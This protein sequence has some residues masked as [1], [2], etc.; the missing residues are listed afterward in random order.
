[1]KLA[2]I[3]HT[4]HFKT[5]NG[6]IVGWSSTVNEINH[7][8]DIFDEIYHVA[9][10]HAAEAP[11]SCLAYASSKIKFVPLKPLGGHTFQ[12]KLHT[13]IQ[14][15]NVIHTVRA[16]LK[17][18]DCFQFRAPTGIGVFLI[19]YLSL[20]SKKKGWFKYA[21]NWNQEKPP[22]GY[23]IQ[24]YLLKNQK[25]KVTI[26]GAWQNQPKHLLTFENPCLTIADIEEG[27]QLVFQ[28]SI[29]GKL[30]FCF[31]GRLEK[32]KGVQRILEAFK[33]LSSAE[34]SRI[35]MLHFIGDGKEREHF[36]SFAKDIGVPTT[37]HG[38]LSRVSVIKIYK[39]CQGFLLP[40]SSEGF[41]KV[42]A[43]AMNFG[44]IPIVSNVSAIAQYII[45]YK[46]GFII[47]PIH[48]KNVSLQVSKVLQLDDDKYRSILKNQRDMVKRFTF[49]YYN[50]RIQE[51][52]V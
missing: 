31:V 50:Q 28:K 46:T 21:G 19:P 13:V 26:N 5:S 23:G 51:E 39:A 32:S 9:M 43:E 1:M 47:S 41:P 15:P 30:Q 14:A 33:L 44:C 16:T 8:L 7:L 27:H 35:E 49:K 29:A 42:I 17:K 48:S 18:V 2:I 52:I 4:E 38:Y 24:R 6:T 10:L 36:E 34:K 22:I 11:P 20:F 12:S 40:S 3:S 25:R 37:F 45:P